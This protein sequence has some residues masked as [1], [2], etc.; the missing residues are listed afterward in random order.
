MKQFF[1]NLKHFILGAA[2]MW[3]ILVTIALYTQVKENEEL[4][5]DKDGVYGEL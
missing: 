2:S 1:D 5:S 4:K 3:T